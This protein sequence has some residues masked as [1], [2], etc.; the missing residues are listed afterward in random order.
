M[1]GKEKR[2][3][4]VAS[5]KTIETSGG[6]PT[7]QGVVYVPDVDII[8][9]QDTITLWADLPG[10]KKENLNIDI[11]DNTLTITGTIESIEE[12]FRP[13]YRE[14]DVGGFTRQFT[15]GEKI[16]QSKISA[17]LDSGVLTLVLPKAEP[18]KPRK[19]KIA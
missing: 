2:E 11:R 10:V 12:R 8:E 6:E 13:V 1:T 14:Y 3:L 7:R 17:T 18:H 19:I 15:L 9:D 5:K 16:D 4:E